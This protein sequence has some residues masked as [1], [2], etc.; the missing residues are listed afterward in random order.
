MILDNHDPERRVHPR[1]QVSLP[2]RIAVDGVRMDADIVDISEGGALLAGHDL[3]S[4]SRVR[5]EIE[6]A[7]LGWHVLDAEVVRREEAGSPDGERLAT[8]FARVATEGGRDAIR[9]F[10]ETRMGASA[11]KIN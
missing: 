7:E 2:A 3:P 6:L 11:F 9:A 10:F 5:L 1:M 8:R 4:G